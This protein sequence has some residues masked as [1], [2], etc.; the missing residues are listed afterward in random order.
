MQF[1]TFQDPEL[2]KEKI[3]DAVAEYCYDCPDDGCFE[4]IVKINCEFGSVPP[5]EILS[6]R[7]TL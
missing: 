4:V 1:R 5:V 6:V 2:L 7:S 3:Q